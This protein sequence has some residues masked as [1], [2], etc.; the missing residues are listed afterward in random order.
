MKV[1]NESYKCTVHDKWRD[2]C[3][4]EYIIHNLDS[5]T[6]V[7]LNLRHFFAKPNVSESA[8]RNLEQIVRRLYRLFSHCFYYHKDVFEEFEREMSLYK[9]FFEFM[10]KFKFNKKDTLIPPFI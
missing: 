9:R 1:N 5:S 6:E 2:C 8:V 10:I 3:A 4:I 7:I